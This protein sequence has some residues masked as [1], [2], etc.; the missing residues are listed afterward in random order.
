MATIG[1]AVARNSYKAVNFVMLLFIFRGKSNSNYSP[2]ML[3]DYG[4]SGLKW[5]K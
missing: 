2:G 4:R 3:R 5:T 1:T